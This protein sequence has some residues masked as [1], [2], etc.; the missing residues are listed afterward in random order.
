MTICA[1]SRSYPTSEIMAFYDRMKALADRQVANKGAAL[2]IKGVPTAGDPVTGVGASD[3]A[4]RTVQGVVTR[5]DNRV[6]PDTLTQSGD[7]MLL[8]EGGA[9]LAVNEKWVN[10]VSDWSIVAVQQVIPNNSTSL[11]YKALVRG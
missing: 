2:T 11:I 7:L 5:V 4:T 10:G 6:F 8:T 1:Y 9:A 3:G